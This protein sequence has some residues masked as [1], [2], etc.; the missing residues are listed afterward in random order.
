MNLLRHIKVQFDFFINTFALKL[1]F[2]RKIA[3]LE[4][5]FWK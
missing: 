3:K 2:W 1:I 4:L 5:P